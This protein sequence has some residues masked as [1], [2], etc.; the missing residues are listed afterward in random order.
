MVMS[1]TEEQSVTMT[2]DAVIDSFV[3]WFPRDA[4]FAWSCC[5]KPINGEPCYVGR[6]LPWMDTDTRPPAEGPPQ[7]PEKV[8]ASSFAFST[9]V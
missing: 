3:E 9:T 2:E 5:Q 7:S 8:E 6:H 1:Q 4:G